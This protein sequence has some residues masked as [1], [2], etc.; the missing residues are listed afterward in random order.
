MVRLYRNPSFVRLFLGRIVTNAGDSIYAVAAMWLVY[1]LTG[2]SFYTGIAGFL[3]FATQPLQVLVGPLVDRWSLRRVLVGTQFVQ[4]VGVLVVPLAAATGHLSVWLVIVLM[5]VLEFLNQ[6]VYPAQHAAL[7]R[8]VEKDQLV[9]AN[10]AFSFAYQGVDMVFNAAAGA[11]IALVGA[12]T[13]YLFDAVTFAVALVLFVGLVVTSAS[14]TDESDDAA[15]VENTETEVKSYL[16]ELKQGFG[17]IRGS[18][19]LL[20]L[21]GAAVLNFAFG[22]AMAVLPAFADS[23]G[24]PVVYGLLT[25]AMGAGSLVGAVGASLVKKFPYGRVVIVGNLLS[26]VFVFAALAVPGLWPT[27]A[28]FFCSFIPTGTMGVMGSSMLQSAVSDSILGRVMSVRNSVSTLLMPFGALLGGWIATV[29]GS[30]TV[31]AGLGVASVFY[32]VYFLVLPSLRSL[33][34]VAAADEK[35]LG[36]HSPVESVDSVEERSEI[37]D[38]SN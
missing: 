7:P 20:F 31:I 3:V 14:D 6:F 15:E 4:L 24:G 13:L 19:V 21:L 26:A 29:I 23:L 1:D 8:I 27:V 34:P 35:V 28:L 36:L 11:L 16:E 30:A 10:S 2:S 32:A 38:V 17:Y 22:M 18:V 9:R 12:V 25:A 5:P 37:D 33:P